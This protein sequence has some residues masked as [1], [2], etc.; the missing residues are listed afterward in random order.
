MIYAVDAAGHGKALYNFQ[1]GADGA[2]P[3]C[4]IRDSAGNLYGTTSYGG[5]ADA[6]QIFKVSPDGGKTTLYSFKGKADG[7]NPGCLVLIRQAIFTA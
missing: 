2:N 1:G 4:L 5:A 3:Q 7:G 6:G